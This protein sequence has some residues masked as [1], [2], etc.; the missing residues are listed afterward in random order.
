MEQYAQI[1][2]VETSL[3]YYNYIIGVDLLNVPT[4]PPGVETANQTTLI[5]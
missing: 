3:K 4:C 5:A 2:G 1:V